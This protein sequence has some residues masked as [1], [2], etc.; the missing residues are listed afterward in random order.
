MIPT[1]NPNTN[2]SESEE[3]TMHENPTKIAQKTHENH[4]SHKMEIDA[5]MNASIHRRS[6]SL[7]NGEDNLA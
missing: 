3:Q 5:T 1:K 2:T 6:D 7:Q 4:S